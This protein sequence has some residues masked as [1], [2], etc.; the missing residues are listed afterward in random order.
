MDPIVVQ[1][2]SQAMVCLFCFCLSLSQLAL[3]CLLTSLPPPGP[4]ALQEARHVCG[5]PSGPGEL[6]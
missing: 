6:T 2:D 4:E 5:D 3:T 1:I